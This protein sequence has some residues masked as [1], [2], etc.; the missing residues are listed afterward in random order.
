MKKVIQRQIE[1][2][3]LKSLKAFPA[4]YIA[5][6]RQSGKTT[7]AKLIAKE[8]HKAQYINFDD[9][10]VR[11]AAARD[12]EAFLRAL[13]EP[14]ILDEVQMVP[15]LF[16]PLKILIDE[17]R[18][19]QGR[20]CGQFLLTG[21]AS[22]MALP[23][24]SDALV[25]RMVLHKLFPL[26]SCELT[27]IADNDF[28]FR[29]FSG[30]WYHQVIEEENPRSMLTQAS[31]PELL[32]LESTDLYYEWCNGYLNTILQRDVKLLLEIEKVA[33]LPDMLRLLASRTGG[34]LNEASLSRETQL[35]H[36]T[37]KKY[38]TL[39]ENLFLT[40]SIPAWS[41]N[42]GKRLIKSPKV[43]LADINFLLYLLNLNID[44][45]P[46]TQPTLWGQVLENFVAI[47]LCKQRTFSSVRTQLYHYR[48]SDGQEVDFI[49]EGPGGKIVA[50]EVKST[51]KV[52]E[53]DF[54]HIFRLKEA[55]GSAFHKG[56]VIYQG[57][58]VV[59]F[60]DKAFAIPLQS[61]WLYTE[62][63]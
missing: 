44:E 63:D 31:F 16:R 30:D 7:L 51:S 17:N 36:L 21:S 4:V 29:A 2:K 19:K 53:K 10:Q 24:L 61:L 28:I 37:T 52:T 14:V 42:L 46:S 9:I 35:N 8:K 32:R 11:S 45:I 25:G 62:R 12:P 55:V 40:F 54:R 5:G 20:G 23:Q 43:Y 58:E 39:L 60:G 41:A 47:E 1:D 26:S 22:V 57:K 15:E 6:P 59:S 56:F 13:K 18:D 33:N 34:I 49:L 48:T 27:S 38:R 3:L 50:I